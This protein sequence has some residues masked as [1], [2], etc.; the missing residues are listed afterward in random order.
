M[1]R[2]GNAA[3]YRPWPATNDGLDAPA[4]LVRTCRRNLWRIKFADST[5][6]S[7]TG[8][9]FWPG[10][11]R[12]RGTCGVTWLKS[13]DE[14]W[15]SSCRRQSRLYRQM[16]RCRWEAKY[17]STSTTHCPKRASMGASHGVVFR[18]VLTSR[19]VIER[20]C[21]ARMPILFSWRISL[22]KLAGETRSVPR[23]EAYLVPASLLERILGLDRPG[24]TTWR[25]VCFTSGSTGE[26]KGAMLSHRNIASNLEAVCQ[27]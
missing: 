5:G 1:I 14:W 27:S 22:Q 7:L 16:P 26:P 24:W 25:T 23:A 13:D 10:H 11:L 9:P 8:G 15:G 2:D 18:T 19:R 12:W 17:P 21:C 4:D 6:Q 20:L 3:R